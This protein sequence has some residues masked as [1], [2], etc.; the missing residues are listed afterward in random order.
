MSFGGVWGLFYIGETVTSYFSSGQWQQQ[1][2]FSEQIKESFFSS[3]HWLFLSGEPIN[4]SGPSS[5]FGTDQRKFSVISFTGPGKIKYLVKVI[6]W[7]DSIKKE[8][9]DHISLI[10]FEHWQGLYPI[11]SLWWFRGTN[12]H[13]HSTLLKD[14]KK[15]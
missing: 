2:L 6:Y 15:L 11:P 3:L 8:Q 10:L 14:K 7:I 13:T 4:V 1:L 9:S 5:R 12:Q